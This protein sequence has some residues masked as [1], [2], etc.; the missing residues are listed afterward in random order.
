MKKYNL[1]KIMKRAWELV[2]KAGVS[3]S[4]ALKKA[5]KEAKGITMKGTEKQVKWASD[6]KKEMTEA[7]SE[8]IQQL[9]EK[10]RLTR[11]ERYESFL[12]KLNEVDE[13]KF[14]IDNR[15]ALYSYDRRH[16]LE[17]RIDQD[18]MNTVAVLKKYFAN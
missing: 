17:R 3:I 4:G 1:S 5:W 12:E 9:R 10:G 18:A 14:F 11:A 6:I 2:K 15:A 13:A 8:Y 16:F 7:L